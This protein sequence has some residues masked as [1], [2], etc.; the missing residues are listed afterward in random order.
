M[1]K[2]SLRNLR[3]RNEFLPE[4]EKDILLVEDNR[5]NVEFMLEAFEK[6]NLV[7]RVKIFQDGAKALDY[8]FTPGEY[9]DC[10]RY[11]QLRV[12]LLDL[13]LPKVGGLE[14]L[15][16]IKSNELTK[17]IPV[18]VFTSSDRYEDRKESYELGA[19]SYIVKPHSHESF[20]KT[21]SEIV[22]YWVLRNV[23]YC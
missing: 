10:N 1:E 22:S 6:H 2:A 18:V 11:T 20:I 14:V 9:S 23:P 4:N 12:I 15:R 3:N 16:E 13:G 21:V 19:N 17:M 7:D 8:L 5:Y